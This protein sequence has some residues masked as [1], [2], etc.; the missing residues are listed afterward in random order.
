MLPGP[1]WETAWVPGDGEGA[2]RLGTRRGFA[3]LTLISLLACAACSSP[4]SDHPAADALTDDTVTVA[5][6]NFAE[7]EV[8]AEIY[9]Q[10]LEGRGVAVR[11]AFDLGPREFVAPV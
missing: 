2:A 1:L 8:L 5:S 4:S 10:A 9:S 7:S 11:R 6:F 3:P